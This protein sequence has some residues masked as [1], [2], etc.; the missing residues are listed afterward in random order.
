MKKRLTLGS[1]ILEIQLSTFWD[2]EI[3]CHTEYEAEFDQSISVCE[4][5]QTPDC[6]CSN[7]KDQS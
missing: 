7:V 3:F 5:N 2:I 4:A 1:R 6:N